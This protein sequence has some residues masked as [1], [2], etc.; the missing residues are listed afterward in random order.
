MELKLIDNQPFIA[1]HEGKR[2]TV[3]TLADFKTTQE[4]DIYLAE[5]AIE[6]LTHSAQRAQRAL[7]SSVLAGLS[8]THTRSE[9]AAI[10]EEVHGLQRDI[11]QARAAITQAGKLVDAH[12]AS[13]LQQTSQTAIDALLKP[14]N[15]FL[16]TLK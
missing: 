14:F 2:E 6:D 4:A 3:R 7:E 13:Q 16:E 1:I 9:L 12:R 11:Q 5:S 10:A 15:D 8:T